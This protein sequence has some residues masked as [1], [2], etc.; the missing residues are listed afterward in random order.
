MYKVAFRTLLAL[1]NVL[2]ACACTREKLLLAAASITA[3]TIILRRLT[4]KQTKLITNYAKVARKVD[5]NG[6]EFDEWDFIIV[7][8]G[9]NLC[10]TVNDISRL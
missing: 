6:L 5:D 1:I 3:L 7:G 4:A 8:G 9:M 10:P 2:Q